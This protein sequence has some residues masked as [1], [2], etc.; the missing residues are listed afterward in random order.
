[1]TFS[2]KVYKYSVFVELGNYKTFHKLLECYKL[3]SINSECWL[4]QRL[5]FVITNDVLHDEML[6]K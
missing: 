6:R 3:D 1:M 2:F 4:F 5:H